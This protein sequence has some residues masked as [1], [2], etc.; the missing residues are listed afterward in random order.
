[1][2]GKASGL[3]EAFKRPA[4]F[5]PGRVHRYALWRRWQNGRYC[6]F[7]GLNPSTADEVNDD[8]TVRRCIDYAKRWGYPA[9]CMT[10]LFAFRST[11]PSD[12]RKCQDPVGKIN[13]WALAHLASNAAIVV[14]A[15]GTHGTYLNR[16]A[17]VR[18]LLPN[19]HYLRLTK[20]GHP[21]HPLYLPKALVPQP[22]NTERKSDDQMV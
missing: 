22:W 9:L 1:M 5:S 3:I 17:Q 15:W 10:N 7:I 20:D 21:N 8:N 6:M 13:D 16:E 18:R 4:V 14:A 2:E 19:L 11:Y 12:L